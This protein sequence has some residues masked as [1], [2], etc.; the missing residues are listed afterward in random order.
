MLHRPDLLKLWKLRPVLSFDAL[1]KDLF[2]L[3][4]LVIWFGNA[5][6]VRVDDLPSF[7]GEV[8]EQLGTVSF[9][10]DFFEFVLEGLRAYI[11]R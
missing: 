9:I 11:G 1:V 6:D 8:L 2:G 7:D 10:F 3:F 4:R 5:L